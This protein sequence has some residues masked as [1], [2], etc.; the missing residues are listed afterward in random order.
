MRIFNILAIFIYTLFFSIIGGVL[1]ALSLR[2]ASLDSV[3][4]AIEYLSQTENLRMGMAL[5]GAALILVNISI[6]QLSIGKLRKNKAI[7]FEN[8]D[9]QVTLSLSAIEDYVKKLTHR[10]PEIR[11]IRSNISVGRNGVLVTARVVLYSDVNIPE[12]TEKVQGAIRIRLQEMLGLEEKVTIKVHVS[13]I[14]QRDKRK[15]KKQSKQETQD[16]A[17]SG[18]K[19]EIKY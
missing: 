15:D 1:I 9:G 17:E 10:I 14:A 2:T 16:A 11:D 4:S 13:K 7:A 8:P 3:L 18:F 6:A 19:G 12:T 5:T